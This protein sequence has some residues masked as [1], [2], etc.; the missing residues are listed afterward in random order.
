MRTSKLPDAE[1]VALYNSGAKLND[2]VAQAGIC[3][4]AVRNCL[5]RNNNY[6]PTRGTVERTCK[7]CGERFK[8]FQVRIK[9]GGGNFC[10]VTCFHASRSLS[11]EYSKN[12]GAMTRVMES[13][14]S[15]KEVTSRQH[16]RHAMKAI[17]DH[18]NG[19]RSDN[20]AENLRVFRSQSEHMQ[21]HH[22]QKNERPHNPR[23]SCTMCSQK[24]RTKQARA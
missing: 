15:E 23:C 8:S 1:I 17:V 7:F 14:K 11:G 9:Q 20:R 22:K 4:Q 13:V 19:D 12:G 18:I 21:F 5:I 2:I 10:S 24:V 3:R 16:G 6:N